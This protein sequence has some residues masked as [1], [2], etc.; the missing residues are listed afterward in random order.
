M[1][2]LPDTLFRA[3]TEQIDRWFA[4]PGTVVMKGEVTRPSFSKRSLRDR[5]IHIMAV[6]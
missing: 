4:V 5:G 1:A 2:A 3:W 6:S